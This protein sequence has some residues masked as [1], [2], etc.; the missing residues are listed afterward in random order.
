MSN[1]TS[2]CDPPQPEAIHNI[3]IVAHQYGA[4]GIGITRML[5][6]SKTPATQRWT[7]RSVVSY[8]FADT[9]QIGILLGPLSCLGQ[10]GY[11]LVCV[12]LDLPTAVTRADEFLPP[13][14]MIE[15]RRGK[16]RSHRYY[17]VSTKSIPSA[18]QRRIQTGPFSRG[19]PGQ[20]ARD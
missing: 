7:E 18:C 4:A 6:G 12:D 16:P 20:G 8:E 11:S 13:T 9:D 14:R 3:N 2:A 10:T 1:T 15:G 5:P 19:G 17:L